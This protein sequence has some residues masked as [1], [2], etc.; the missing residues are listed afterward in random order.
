VG[1][2]KTAL[3]VMM[4]KVIYRECL[5][6][7]DTTSLEQLTEDAV[8]ADWDDTLSKNPQSQ[9]GMDKMGFTEADIREV[10]RRVIPKLR[11]EK[12]RRMRYVTR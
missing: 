6:T 8:M 7:L 9:Q 2:K 12:E 5:K 10:V 1:F 4:E 11:N 3:R